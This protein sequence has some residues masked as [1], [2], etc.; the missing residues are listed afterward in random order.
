MGPWPMPSRR[1]KPI[2]RLTHICTTAMEPPIA[3]PASLV[4]TD[5][6]DTHTP[7]DTDTHTLTTSPQS[8]LSRP[9]RSPTTLWPLRRLSSPTT[10]TPSHTQD[11]QDTPHTATDPP[12]DITFPSPP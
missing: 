2:P 8:R 1:P 10:T 7:T 5:T 3:T 12:T 11:T 4:D 9:R 6:P